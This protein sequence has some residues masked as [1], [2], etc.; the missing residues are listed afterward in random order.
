[1]QF[2][3]R[4]REWSHSVYGFNLY[5]RRQWVARYASLLPAGAR[6]L[7]AGAG[8]G[9]YRALFAHCDYKAH[10]FG[11]EPRTVGHYTPLDYQ[12]DIL[13]IAAPDGAFDVILCTEVLEHVPEPIKALGELSRLLRPGGVMM[14]SAPLGCVLHQEPYIFYGGYTPYWYRRFLGEAGCD[15]ASIESNQGFFS[16]FADYSVWFNNLIHPRETR[17]EPL[18]N[19]LLLFVLWLLS[20][21]AVRILAPL[22]R[23]LDRRG[24]GAVGTV[25]YHVVAVKRGGMP[26]IPVQGQ[27][28]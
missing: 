8:E 28:A 24:Y 27:T 6:V 13:A 5:N 20:R 12:S 23:W 3:A 22:G 2:L 14:L 10:D 4:L 26:L 7:D 9:Q 16:L 11:Q 19:R 1:V 18:P 21:P 25:G 15:V 17:R